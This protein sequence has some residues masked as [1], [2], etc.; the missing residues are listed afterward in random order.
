MQRL[1]QP[2]QPAGIAVVVARSST[3]EVKQFGGTGFVNFALA[4]VE[5]LGKLFVDGGGVERGVAER[6]YNSGQSGRAV[7]QR[8]AQAEE[9]DQAAPV[10]KAGRRVVGARG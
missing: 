4:E 6:F 9:I 1:R 3:F 10:L 7:G 8:V 2:E 5:G